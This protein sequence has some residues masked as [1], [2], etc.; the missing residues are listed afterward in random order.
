MCGGWGSCRK[1]QETAV[2]VR[3]AKGQKRTRQVTM[4]DMHGELTRVLGGVSAMHGGGQARLSPHP[5]SPRHNI[6][7]LLAPEL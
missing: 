5:T 2:L 4:F 3:G 7:T 6:S 1:Q